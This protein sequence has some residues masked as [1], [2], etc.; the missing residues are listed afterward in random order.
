M[1]NVLNEEKK[2]QVIALGQLGWALRRIEEATGVRR[3]TAARYLKAAGIPVRQPRE[4]P[5]G[6]TTSQIE[7]QIA[8]SRETLGSNLHELEQKVKAVTDW[9]QHFRTSP[10][11]LL[12]VAFGGGV[13]L[14]TMLGGRGRNGRSSPVPGQPETL[15]GTSYQKSQALETWDKIKGALMGV[16][17]TRVKDYVDEII[18]GFKEEFRRSGE[19][20]RETQYSGR[21]N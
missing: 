12:G 2:K 5:M 4:R 6:E 17:A 18:P 9:K 11:M 19:K 3:E 8:H 20:T 13:V 7:A 14:A 15:M 16:A 21:T 1:S 10:V